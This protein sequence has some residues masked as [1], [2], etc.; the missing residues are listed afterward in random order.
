MCVQVGRLQYET[1]SQD[2]L[3]RKSHIWKTGEEHGD[4]K[5]NREGCAWYANAQSL[6]LLPYRSECEFYINGTWE[7]LRTS[8]AL[9]H[10]LACCQ[11]V[12]LFAEIKYLGT[13]LVEN[14]N[15]R[16]L[17]YIS[18]YVERIDGQIYIPDFRWH[19]PVVFHIWCYS[20]DWRHYLH[21]NYFLLL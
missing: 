7:V 15:F 9:S 20:S 14:I 13:I 4:H 21:S 12:F 11:T 18:V 6:T 19:Q 10:S 1:I 17:E 2:N 16:D 3:I 8:I 5:S